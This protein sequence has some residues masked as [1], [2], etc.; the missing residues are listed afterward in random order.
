MHA[1]PR[2]I[3][4][5]RSTNLE[6]I[7]RKVLAGD[8]GN[9]T[10]RVEHLT[11]M[12]LTA[13]QIDAVQSRVNKLVG[14]AAT[15]TR[16]QTVTVQTSTPAGTWQGSRPAHYG[17]GSEC[18]HYMA[19]T[20]A[21]AMWSRGAQDWHVEKMLNVISRESACTTTAYNYS[22]ATKDTSFGLCQI[23]QRAGWFNSG[24]LLGDFNPHRFAGNPE[25][26]AAACATLWAR[27]GFL[28]WRYGNYGCQ[29]PI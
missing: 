25:Y 15:Y 28:P 21:H 24:Q 27:C 9:G 14:K 13:A 3:H 4:E 17:P 11:N 19:D 23:N 1:E 7:A 12:G 2:P 20:V 6:T 22:D 26:N 10:A 18:S 5:N 29:R 8:Y 16:T